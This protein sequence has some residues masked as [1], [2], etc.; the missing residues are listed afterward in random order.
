MDEEV[1]DTAVILPSP[2]A[3][4]DVV[5][6]WAHQEAA[7]VKR[8]LGPF[9]CYDSRGA[10]TTLDQWSFLDFLSRKLGSRDKGEGMIRPAAR[11]RLKPVHNA[12]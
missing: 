9:V 4:R 1:G 7:F 5:V 3:G 6:Q 10:R 2:F 12:S 8:G 11:A